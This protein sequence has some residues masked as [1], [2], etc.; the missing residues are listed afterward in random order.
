MELFALNS[1]VVAIQAGK[2]GGGFTYISE[3]LQKMP[4]QSFHNAHEIQ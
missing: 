1:M 3:E 2:D 4:E